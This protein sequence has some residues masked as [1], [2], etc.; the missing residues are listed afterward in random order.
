MSPN[1]RPL[2]TLSLAFVE[3]LYADFM[4]DPSSVSDDWQAYFATLGQDAN[5]ASKPK[6]GPSFRPAS[7]FGAPAQRTNGA[8]RPNGNGAVAPQG[9]SKAAVRQDQVD[10]LVRAYRVRG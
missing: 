8:S 4:R 7:L 5:F 3:G 6:L 10:A 1:Q 9:V 2:N